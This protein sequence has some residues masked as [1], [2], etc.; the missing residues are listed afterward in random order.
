MSA[1]PDTDEHTTYFY[2][3]RYITYTV[4]VFEPR[5]RVVSL[6]YCSTHPSFHW[7]YLFS[8]VGQKVMEERSSELGFC[9]S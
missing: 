7:I 5:D 3:P 1:F 4:L 2:Y 9:D 6:C 8:D